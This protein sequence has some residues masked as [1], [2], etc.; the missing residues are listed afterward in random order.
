MVILSAPF[1][2]GQVDKPRIISALYH[3]RHTGASRKKTAKRG[4]TQAVSSGKL[5]M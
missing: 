4:L 2:G 1:S 3:E 5:R